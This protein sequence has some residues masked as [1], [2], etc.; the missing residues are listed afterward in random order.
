MSGAGGVSGNRPPGVVVILPMKPSPVAPAGSRPARPVVMTP[1]T[2]DAFDP[3]AWRP[4]AVRRFD[5]RP[6]NDQA[7]E[8]ALMDSLVRLPHALPV[9]GAVVAALAGLTLGLWL[10]L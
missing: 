8:P 2:L 4:P 5:S 9:A 1:G 6:A 10:S 3:V 7:V